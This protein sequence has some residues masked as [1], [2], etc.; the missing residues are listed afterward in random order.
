M[1]PSENGPLPDAHLMCT[2]SAMVALA[3]DL[4]RV[5]GYERRLAAPHIALEELKFLAPSV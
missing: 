1:S 2:A 3:A 5:Q 4:G